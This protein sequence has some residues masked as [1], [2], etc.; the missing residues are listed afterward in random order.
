MV[1]L[2]SIYGVRA[3][4]AAPPAPICYLGLNQATSL[5]EH[6]AQ[7]ILLMQ[8]R[9]N[10]GNFSKTLKTGAA[11]RQSSWYL[12][13]HGRAVLPLR[14]RYAPKAGT[15]PLGVGS[16]AIPVHCCPPPR[17]RCAL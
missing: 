9:D 7:V 13:K 15:M 14:F 17:Q 4:A 10:K 6:F 11:D 1:V 2:P 16:P 3:F 8:V 12:G 5:R